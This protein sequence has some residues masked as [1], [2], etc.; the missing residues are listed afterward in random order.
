MHNKPV[1]ELHVGEVELDAME[2][3]RSMTWLSAH[4]K[5][6]PFVICI[7]SLAVW[8]GFKVV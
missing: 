6:E 7:G 2:G 1:A 5:K 3:M 4:Q 8:L